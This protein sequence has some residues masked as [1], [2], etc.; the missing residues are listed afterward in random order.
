MT[1]IVRRLINRMD[2]MFGFP[3]DEAI[4]RR[5]RAWDY[6]QA[7]DTA[8]WE[9]E[10]DKAGVRD[11]LA[12]LERDPTAGFAALKAL[13]EE[14]SVW[15]MERLGRCYYQGVGV[16]VDENKAEE[17]CRRAF[18]GGSQRALLDYGRFL[19]LR[20]DFPACEEVYGV[21]A[22]ADWGP[23]LYWLA[24]SRLNRSR[25]PATALQVRPLLERA[26]VE[27]S[28]AAQWLLGW[29]MGR[30]K[31]GWREMWGG[32][33]MLVSFRNRMLDAFEKEKGNKRESA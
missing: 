28:P 26:S 2:A 1:A 25:S 12:T 9:R 30:G 29:L 31:Y 13:A 16:A 3:S 22:A 4:R 8:V 14:G 19:A 5:C 15:C 33:R 11:A 20:D 27:C 17:W 6:A 7:N 18:E 24:R 23:A 32:L 21:G 10:R